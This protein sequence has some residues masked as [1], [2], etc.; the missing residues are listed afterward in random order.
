MASLED[1]DLSA[2][3]PKKEAKRRLK[4]A[5]QRLLELRLQLGGQVGD[6]ELGPGV[7][8]VLEGWDASGKGGAIKRLVSGL[9]SRHVTVAEFAAPDERERRHHFLWRFGSGSRFRI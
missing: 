4:A 9:D 1:V 3:L 8:I 5:Q 7:C 2:R 6:G